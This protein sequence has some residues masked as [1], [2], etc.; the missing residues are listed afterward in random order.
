MIL[1]QCEDE[2]T[3]PEQCSSKSCSEDNE[4]YK[5]DK[6][7]CRYLCWKLYITN[8]FVH[9]G[10]NLHIYQVITYICR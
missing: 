3:Q 4:K 7:I 2:T 5:V 1:F 10:K 6:V 9:V 8:N